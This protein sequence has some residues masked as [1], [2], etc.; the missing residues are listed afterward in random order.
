MPFLVAQVKCDGG[1]VAVFT[2]GNH[3]DGFTGTEYPLC[4]EIILTSRRGQ[5]FQF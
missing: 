1:E 2:G 4:G 5:C 3:A